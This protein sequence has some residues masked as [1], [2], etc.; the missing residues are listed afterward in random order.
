MSWRKRESYRD[1]ATSLFFGCSSLCV[2]IAFEFRNYGSNL[3]FYQ[4]EQQ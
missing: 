1:N 4:S 3:I 2:V